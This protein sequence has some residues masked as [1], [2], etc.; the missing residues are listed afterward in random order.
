MAAV[1]AAWEAELEQRVRSL[2]VPRHIA[3]IMDGNGRWA[4]QRGLPRVAGHRAGAD[5]L[6]DVV[7]AAGEL[8]VAYLTLFAFST[9]NWRRPPEEVDVLMKLLEEYLERECDELVAAGVRLKSI[10]RIEAL[11][12][13]ARDAL[14]RAEDRTRGGDRVTVVLALNYGGRSE[15]VDAARRLCRMALAGGLDPASLDEDVFR[16][17]LYTEGIPDPDL[18]IRPGGEMRVSNFLL[19]QLAYAEIWV[20]PVLWPDFRRRH[21]LE[22]IAD[23][24]RR[25]RRFGGLSPRG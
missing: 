20:T 14:R 21:L 19:W 13:P 5:A 4:Q 9:E 12:A 10:G 8:G 1:E 23:Y 11:P 15:I 3:I 17:A 7:R 2:P 25:E 6:R 18:L 24:Q 16:E 22:A